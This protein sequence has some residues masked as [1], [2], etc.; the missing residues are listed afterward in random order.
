MGLQVAGVLLLRFL[1]VFQ[2]LQDENILLSVYK[3]KDTAPEL[4]TLPVCHPHLLLC[5]LHNPPGTT[6]MKAEVSFRRL[7]ALA[8]QGE[9]RMCPLPE[10]EGQVEGPGS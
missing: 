5:E 2:M 8:F 10:E 7:G 1:H 6:G 4:G 3:N 9:S